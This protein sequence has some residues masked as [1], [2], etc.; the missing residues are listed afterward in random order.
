[1]RLIHCN[2]QV[3]SGNGSAFGYYIWHCFGAGVDWQHK[4]ATIAVVEDAYGRIR[5]P[6]AECCRFVTDE[7]LKDI[8]VEYDREV[9]ILLARI[10]AAKGAS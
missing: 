9:P 10:K 3:S 5:M 2:S 7:D 4:P 8:D 1:M 6:L